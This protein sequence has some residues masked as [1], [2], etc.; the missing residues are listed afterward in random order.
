MEKLFAGD[1][2]HSIEAIATRA[3]NL[4]YAGSRLDF[5][6]VTASTRSDLHPEAAARLP[7][8]AYDTPIGQFGFEPPYT[9]LG[10]YNAEKASRYPFIP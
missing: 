10:M 9:L 6:T 5:L 1:W 8:D 3:A 7:T 4:R 2:G